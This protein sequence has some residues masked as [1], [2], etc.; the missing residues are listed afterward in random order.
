MSA[1]I[2]VEGLGKHYAIGRTGAQYRTLREDLMGAVAA[3]WRALARQGRRS[4]EAGS[5]DIWALRDVSFEVADGEVFGIIGRNGAGKSTLLKLL[6]RIVMPTTGRAIVRGRVGTLLEVGAGFHPELTG[7]DNVYLS[8]SILGM[9]RAEITHKFDEIVEFSGVERFLDTPVK[10][11]STGMYLRLAFAVAAH[12]EADILIVD[13]VL[14]VG[15]AEFQKKCLGRMQAVAGTGRTVLFVSHNMAA[16]RSLCHRACVLD[17]G[18]IVKH[19]DVHDC[20]GYYLQWHV[21]QQNPIVQFDPPA[22]R[23][24]SMTSAT[25][26]CDGRPS[27]RILMGSTL[28]I[29]VSFRSDTPLHVPRVGFIVT[30]EAGIALLSANNRYQFSPRYDKPVQAGTISCE[31]GAVPLMPGRYSVSLFLGDAPE[32]DSHVAEHVLW[33]E[34]VEHD[35]WGTGLGPDSRASQLWW[36]TTFHFSV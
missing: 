33:F 31:L 11:Y 24:P 16:V 27:I 17:A 4:E 9:T 19:G 20:I 14:A 1:R 6:S 10:R 8:G 7:R 32:H 30:N 34:V 35:L 21:D 36:P 28:G 3:P 25:L 5:S 29:K 22:G 13:E 18:R 26:L 23:S 12:L 15:D 2:F